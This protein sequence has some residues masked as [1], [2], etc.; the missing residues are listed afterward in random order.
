[1]K[2]FIRLCLLSAGIAGLALPG[3]AAEQKIA[4]FNLRKAFDGY[5]KTIQ[6]TAALKSEAADVDKE[7]SQLVEN[8][9]KHDDEWRKLIDKANDQSLS[10]EER[11][12]SKKAAADKYAEL[13]SDKDYI[14]K[15]DRES[16]A[17]LHE[18][19]R[20]RRDDIVKEILGVVEAHAKTSGYTMV[21]DPSGQ[22]ENL[23]PVVLYTNGQDDMTD[24]IIKEL[25]AAAP[26][27]SLDTNNPAAPNL[28][29][30]VPPHK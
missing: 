26:P 15:F 8:G 28:L 13:E 19:E 12:K 29:Q 10:A 25:N 24:G 22:S 9:R 14:T 2:K 4:T 11:E 6:S 5:Y 18:K 16:A 17:R 23:V 3:R 20:Q 30:G 27:G 1:M 21:L 7:R